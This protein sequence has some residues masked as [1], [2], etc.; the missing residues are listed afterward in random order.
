[1][2]ESELIKEGHYAAFYLQGGMG[3]HFFAWYFTPG[4]PFDTIGLIGARKD[5]VSSSGRLAK[6]KY[7]LSKLKARKNPYASKFIKPVTLRLT[8]GLS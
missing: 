8:E 1:M 2:D 5:V 4:N 3:C 7:D 6:T